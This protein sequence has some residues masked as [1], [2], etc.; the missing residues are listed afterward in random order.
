VAAAPSAGLG[1][2]F[3]A[4]VAAAV[5][6]AAGGDSAAKLEAV[7]LTGIN[8]RRRSSCFMLEILLE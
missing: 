8:P 1:A 3:G 4:G 6:P 7:I 5:A 2:E